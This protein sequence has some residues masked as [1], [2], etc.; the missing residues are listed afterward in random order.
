[1]WIWE[2]GPVVPRFEGCGGLTDVE[3]IRILKGG[4]QNRVGRWAVG[5]SPHRF[6]PYSVMFMVRLQPPYP[7][8]VSSV[9]GLARASNFSMEN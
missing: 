9:S 1:M 6:G 3:L 4:K 7:Y 5:S 2:K 8:P